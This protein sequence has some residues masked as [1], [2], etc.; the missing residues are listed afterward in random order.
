[1]YFKIFF[2]GVDI[3]G[4]LES[5]VGTKKEI[6]F[7]GNNKKE[8]CNCTTQPEKKQSKIKN[9]QQIKTM[10]EFEN[11]LQNIVFVKTYEEQ[12][13]INVELKYIFYIM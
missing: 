1:M 9:E 11:T 12:I 13:F 2:L 10:I 7:P 4:Q 8:N 3:K 5:Y 6:V